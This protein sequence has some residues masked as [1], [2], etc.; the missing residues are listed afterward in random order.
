MRVG[1]AALRVFSSGGRRALRP[2]ESAA[3]RSAQTLGSQATAGQFD[4]LSILSKRCRVFWS[5]RRASPQ[6][7]LSRSSSFALS[8][9][10][11]G[12]FQRAAQGQMALG[13]A[14][15]ECWGQLE[16]SKCPWGGPCRRR[17]VGGGHRRR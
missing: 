4:D 1:V 13:P 2:S 17:L 15:G 8:A 14:L 3:A 9:F 5:E 6:D 12:A 16:P 7:P 10:S 11:R